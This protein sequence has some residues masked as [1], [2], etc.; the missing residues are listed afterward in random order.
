MFGGKTTKLLGAVE[1]D[2]LRGFT[3]KSFKPKID[4]RYSSDQIITHIG[5]TLDA[6]AV[7]SGNEIWCAVR[8]NQIKSVAIDELFMIP[9]AAEV[10]IKLFRRGINIYASTLQLDSNSEPYEE[11][12]KILPWATEIVVCPAICTIC[13]SDAYYTLK[14]GGDPNAKIE[15]G[16][17]DLYEPRC[18]CH[19]F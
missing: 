16:G 13:G 14:T 15:V 10:A 3:V 6:S 8:D 18:F 9:D 4:T 19:F 17:S 1:R 12:S 2:V 11:V 7:L 5:A